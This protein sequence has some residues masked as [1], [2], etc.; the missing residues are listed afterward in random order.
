MGGSHHLALAHVL[1]KKLKA[2]KLNNPFTLRE[3]K[4]KHWQGFDTPQ[5]IEET[6]DTLEEHGYILREE[7][8]TEGRPTVHYHMNPLWQGEA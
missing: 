7:R 5:V 8:R 6:L 4:R 2:E 1:L 3:L